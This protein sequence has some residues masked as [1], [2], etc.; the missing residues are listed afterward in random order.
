MKSGNQAFQLQR[1]EAERL[2]DAL[3]KRDSGFRPPSGTRG[4]TECAFEHTAGGKITIYWT[5]RQSAR[6]K[7][8]AQGTA[9]T[10]P[11]LVTTITQMAAVPAPSAPPPAAPGG[12]PQPPARTELVSGPAPR[13][14]S[15]DPAE[16]EAEPLDNYLGEGGLGRVTAEFLPDGT[17][18]AVK[19]IQERHYTEPGVEGLVKRFTREIEAMRLLSRHGH[20][21]IVP[22]LAYQ[23]GPVPEYAMPIAPLCLKK[24]LRQ[25]S[26]SLPKLTR[27]YL[28]IL[29]GVEFAHDHGIFHRDLKPGN[30]LLY[31]DSQGYT[32]K[33][34]DFGLCR[35][36]RELGQTGSGICGIGTELYAAPE[37]LKDFKQT[38]HRADI[39]SLGVILFTLVA[40]A[41]PQLRIGEVLADLQPNAGPTAAALALIRKCV[42]ARRQDRF[43]S[44]GALRDH[45]WRVAPDLSVNLSDLK[46]EARLA[47]AVEFSLP[48]V[49]E[50]EAY[51][52]D[53]NELFDE[54]ESFDGDPTWYVREFPTLQRSDHMVLMRSD[55]PRFSRQLL[56]FS[57][58]LGQQW[59]PFSYV[60]KLGAFLQGLLRTGTPGPVWTTGLGVMLNLA[61]H[62]SRYEVADQATE[63]LK[64]ARTPAELEACRVSFEQNKPATRWLLDPKRNRRKELQDSR[65]SQV[66]PKA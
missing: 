41:E 51:R 12:A 6:V 5:A 20:P 2:F 62:H 40:R 31:H 7:V 52:D 8:L 13:G 48:F 25:I 56:H 64:S 10:L 33:V 47:L 63:V 43:S 17:L 14:R 57:K 3:A 38:D 42:A 50:G 66:L 58:A 9:Q 49:R 65:I 34:S 29:A 54:L 55:A 37:Q 26:S 11:Q 46:P 19:R 15:A 22:I 18:V 21:N 32:A 35:I 45:F 1:D 23:D 24:G 44:V 28:Q 16:V 39:Y 30:I 61:H 59:L 36:T 60:D 53:V 4:V 27:A